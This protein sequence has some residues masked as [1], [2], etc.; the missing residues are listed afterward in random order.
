MQ[1]IPFLINSKVWGYEPFKKV[2]T[3]VRGH[4]Y[5]ILPVSPFPIAISLSLFFLLLSIVIS[6]H[7]TASSS[8]IEYFLFYS[9]NILCNLCITPIL[10]YLFTSANSDMQLQE[11]RLIELNSRYTISGEDDSNLKQFYIHWLAPFVLTI[12]LFFLWCASAIEEGSTPNLTFFP[13]TTGNAKLVMQ[14]GISAPLFH[15]N[16]V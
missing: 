2:M 12:G 10:D 5:H 1:K 6:L 13:G 8:V 16:L 15:S 4:K 11:V 14:R 3:A 9:N 7:F